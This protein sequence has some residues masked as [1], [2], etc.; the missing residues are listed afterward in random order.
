MNSTHTYLEFNGKHCVSSH[1]VVG[2][3]ASS[4]LWD[5]WVKD[6]K[7]KGSV[8]QKGG[9][10]RPALIEINA[11]PEKYRNEIINKFGKPEE[12]S[13]ALE[14]HFSID[15]AARMWFDGFKFADGTSLKPEQVNRYTINA[16]VLNALAKLKKARE[17]EHKIKGNTVGNLWPALIN[18]VS[19]FNNTLKLKFGG[20]QHDLPKSEKLR[21][22][23]G[24]YIKNGYSILVDG[25]NKN[26]AAKKVTP[27]MIALWN[28]IFS[29][30]R[31]KP[32][33]LEVA[34]KYNQFLNG[35]IDILNT[36]TGEIYDP[37]HED[38]RPID[39]STV[40]NYISDWT[41]RIAT[42]AKRSGDRQVFKGKYEPYHKLTQPKWAGSIIS[43]DDRQPP[44][45]YDAGK[46][47]WFYNAIDLGSEAFTCW[48]YGETKEGII[49]EFYRQLVRNY[50][51]WGLNM[52][53]EIECESSLNSS[54]KETF[55]M[56]G[57][58][59]SE[60]R[61]EA[62]NAR[63]KRIE[64]YYRTLRYSYEKQREGWLARP[65]VLSES[66]L[67]GP[68]V[69]PFK[70]KEAIVDG[71]LIDIE[72]WNNT[73]HSNQE[74]H[75]GLTRWEVF[76][77]KQHPELKPTNWR[78]ILP[79]LGYSTK[80][81]MKAGRITLQGMHRVV[82]INGEV[83]LG[84]NLINIMSRIEGEEVTLYWLDDNEGNVLKA[85]VYDNA[86]AFVCELLDDL[87]YSRSKL[88]SGASDVDKR[89]LMSAYTAT[90]QGYVSRNVKQL[91]DVV[92]IEKQMETVK[93]FTIKRLG[94]DRATSS[95]IK[96]NENFEAE[97]LPA[98]PQEEDFNDDL[99]SIETGFKV[100]TKSRF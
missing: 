24:A 7:K 9:N 25:R 77:E 26:Q 13:N 11:I 30:Q 2:N 55:L 69:V 53:Y 57:A 12:V 28:D 81:S 98:L 83:A 52:P 63:G 76:M 1:L 86:G 41:S 44:F 59:F 90:V 39:E 33:Y 43:I 10:G 85:H 92:I 65:K 34:F 27:M 84:E 87:S 78:G 16:S 79:H 31:H 97:S 49:T 15:G 19:A 36:S 8:R 80:S 54:F 50:A 37:K 6:A 75:P 62:N 35:V 38:F 5:K 67:A 71:C 89:A 72:T 46:R 20:L 58:M 4:H 32:T 88:E 45:A 42:H 3:I 18:E 91:S 70:S 60:V 74:L 68:G 23:L 22:K 56:P 99:N 66:N 96:I 51:E 40:Y 95:A 48:V 93:K 94:T 47:M 29:G 100:N 61:I 64:A 17:T 82:G 14:A 21:I 73:L